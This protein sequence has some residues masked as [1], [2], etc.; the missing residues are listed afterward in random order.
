VANYTLPYW[1][2]NVGGSLKK[3]VYIC[4]SYARALI[5]NFT[6]SGD[7]SFSIVNKRTDNA[8]SRIRVRTDGIVIHA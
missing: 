6:V 5:P 7:V 2:K 4:C 1:H 8:F 3:A